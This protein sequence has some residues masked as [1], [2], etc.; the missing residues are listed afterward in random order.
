MDN[1]AVCLEKLQIVLPVNAT[2]V[3]QS[4]AEEL[5][6]HIL[7]MT[8]KSMV[9]VT[10]GQQSGRAVYIGATRYA[11]EL[12]VTY[13]DNAFGEGWAMK[14][15]DGNLVLTG[16]K[17]RGT[18]YAVY[19]LLEDELGIHWWNPWEEYVP[20]AEHAV[21]SGDLDKR[22]VPAMKYRDIYISGLQE[23]V[24]Y[25]FATR[26]RLNGFASN[27]PVAYGGKEDYSLPYLAHTFRLYFSPFY[28]EDGED[29]K[30][31]QQAWMNAIGNPNKVNYFE[32]HP[33]W[34]AYDKET[35][36]RTPGG[37]LCLNNEELY[38][39]YEKKFL[40]TIQYCIEKADAEGKPHP[41]YYD[42]TPADVSGHCQCEKCAASIAK[43]GASGNLHRFVN[44]LATAAKKTFPSE[45]F[46]VETLAYWDYLEPPLDDTKPADNVVIRF[47]DN[48]MDI[49]HD[50]HHKNNAS[51]LANLKTW[52][53]LVKKGNLQIWDYGTVYN[54]NGV[55]P[56]MYKYKENQM[57][58][59]A[60][61]VDGYFVELEEYINTDFWD[62]K[63]WL[64]SRIMEVPDQDYDA[65]MNTFLY[66][67]YGK[68]AGKYIR[69]Y[70]DF[71]HEKAE[72]Y[73]G[74]ISFGYSIVAAPWL[75]AADVLKGD[76]LFEKAMSAAG[77]NALYCRRLRAAR[78]GLDRV[79]AEGYSKWW[80]Q[81]E[82]AGIP[83][84]IDKKTVLNRL[85]TALE[86][87]KGRGGDDSRVDLQLAN[88][89]ELLNVM[90]KPPVPVP[91]E[92]ACYGKRNVFEFT[93]VDMDVYDGEMS[94]D[95]DSKYGRVALFDLKKLSEKMPKR[96]D[97]ETIK[98]IWGIEEGKPL[99][100]GMWRGQV[101]SNVNEFAYLHAKDLI[102]DGTY[103]LYK[104]EDVTMV[105]AEQNMFAYL[106]AD[107]K[108]QLFGLPNMI[109]H[110]KDKKVDFYLSMKLTGDISCNDPENYPTFWIDR[111]FV[112]DKD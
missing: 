26:N 97:H 50:I 84:N 99:V 18:L 34:F 21:I 102:V 96:F 13:P 53:K 20:S 69:E 64:L 54:T 85:M 15:V 67:Y 61:D 103:H 30:A 1:C 41:R 2:A 62:M 8:G 66:G 105:D 88:Y 45:D 37:Q 42:V 81:A 87:Q 38:Q 86:E 49:L 11:A 71:M 95:G 65:L 75:H 112:V 36:K 43:H 104:L 57:T 60:H 40:A 100:M 68:E 89:R 4:S 59:L 82:D 110:L 46:S 79:I 12:Q 106:F 3:E 58:F 108:L 28:T 29:G 5:A 24:H 23:A 101:L 91:E 72:A 70:L 25:M 19:H 14:A 44:R 77:G 39:A 76:D 31:D 73:N 27:N 78:C 52:Q 9:T 83:W 90:D 6:I 109:S 94:Y 10:E 55:F 74:H 33:E 48:Y 47:A 35:G 7:K 63:L 51:L 56:S 92:I 80:D 16:S 17:N 32:E 111:M 98:K 93:S 22:G 107:M